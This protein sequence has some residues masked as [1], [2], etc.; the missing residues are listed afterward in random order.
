MRITPRWW[1][2][3]VIWLVYTALVFVVGLV[4]GVPYDEFG[5]SADTL[6]RGP[7]VF[8][9]A[10][11]V[12]LIV[13][14]SILGWWRPAL[15]EAE[16][17]KHRWPIIAPA[18]MALSVIVSLSFGVDWSGI[19]GGY[20]AGLLLL[21]VMV[22]FN[23]ELLTRGLLLTSLRP[24]L[25]EIL[26]WFITSALFGLM[27]VTNI[28]FGADPGSTLQQVGLAFLGGTGFY[29][30][31]RVTGSL[32][33]AMVLHG[34]WD[35]TTFAVGH[36]PAGPAVGPILGT[37]ASVLALVFVWWTF[38]SREIPAPAA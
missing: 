34:A 19:D 36:S 21:G 37:I 17:S 6:F 1:I 24:Q 31:R 18:V 30:V 10:G 33:W 2:G 15:F 7:V 3:V 27:H 12:L 26:V 9:A 20:L 4:S 14:T 16:R 23:E 32:I 35:F 25:R 8:L 38:R 5:D 13:V 11:A 22:G 29:I 28:F